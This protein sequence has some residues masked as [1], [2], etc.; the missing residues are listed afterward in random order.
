MGLSRHATFEDINPDPEV[1]A[2][3]KQLYHTPDHVELYPGT[4]AEKTKP[5]MSPGSGLCGTVTMTTAILSDAVSLV[6]GDRFYTIDYTPK[7]L[8]NWGFNEV[9]GDKAIDGGHVLH[10]LIFRAFPNHFANNSV[11]AHFPLV[12]PA[13]NG[14]ILKGLGKASQY[15][16]ERPRRRYDLAII[17]SYKTCTQVLSNQQ[18]FKVTWGEAINFLSKKS[19]GRVLA[20]E[21]CLAGDGSANASNHD[22]IHKCLYPRKWDSDINTFFAVTTDRLVKQHSHSVASQ[23]GSHEPNSPPSTR[24]YELDIVRDVIALV[25]THFSAALWSLPLRTPERPQGV[26]SDQELYLVLLVCFAAIFFDDDIGSSFTLRSMAREFAQQ[27]GQQIRQSSKIL[28]TGDRL[29]SAVVETLK[30]SFSTK[31]RVGSKDDAATQ[32]EWPALRLYGR[33]MIKRMLKEPGKKVDEAIWG[34]ILP[35]SVAGC[36][37][38]TEALSQAVDYYLGDGKKH[39]PTM[40]SLAHE[41]T[42]EA[43]ETL[44][45]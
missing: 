5:P 34:S 30:E 24:T 35:A 2:R 6:R 18:D 41:G 11:Y 28:S 25:T 12:T 39:L 16:W 23:A 10:K 13:E 43:D 4:V 36:A 38:Q 20:N 27:L 17:R 33:H 40:Y 37:N 3:L 32:S 45:K 14:K 26:Y 21:F 31:V 42:E 29:F 44:K 8:T 22:H 15:S 9:D 19:D 7:L 1:A